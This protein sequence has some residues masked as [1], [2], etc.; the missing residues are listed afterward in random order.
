M[1]HSL[2]Q[3]LAMVVIVVLVLVAVV[4]VAWV[5]A[6]W[7]GASAPAALVDMLIPTPP[8]SPLPTAAQVEMSPVTRSPSQ[9]SLSTA[10]LAGLVDLLLVLVE[11]VLRV[12]LVAR[13]LEG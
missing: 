2:V 5:A 13:Y 7:Q 8:P 1:S 10:L 11:Q 6:R 3:L 12:W 9:T 4:V